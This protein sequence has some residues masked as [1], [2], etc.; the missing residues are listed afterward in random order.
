MPG[1]TT[2]KKTKSRGG[3]GHWPSTDSYSFNKFLF[4]VGPEMNDLI[5]ILIKFL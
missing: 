5:I 3:Q 2:E 4:T 1:G